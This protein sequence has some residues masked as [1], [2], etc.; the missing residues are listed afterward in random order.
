MGS[1]ED[2]AL[3]GKEMMVKIVERIPAH[4]EVHDVEDLGRV[5]KWRPEQVVVECSAC[6]RR[7]TFKRWDLISSLVTC[8]CG[9][10]CS[11]SVRKELLIERL[12]EDEHIHP[13]RYWDSGKIAGVPV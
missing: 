9:A 6:A 7:G 4:Y 13:W 3:C 8:E 11:G 12:A 2:G 10:Q 5:Y 1:R